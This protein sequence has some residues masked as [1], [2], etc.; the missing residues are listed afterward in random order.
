VI[1]SMSGSENFRSTIEYRLLYAKYFQNH[2]S[3]RMVQSDFYVLASGRISPYDDLIR[4]YS[5]EIGW[6][7]RLLASM[8]YQESRFLPD[9]QS[10]A[11]ADGLMQLMPNTA[12]RFGVNEHL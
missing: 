12:R 2:R 8:I 3:A 1:Q 9:A 11:G 5:E 7:W 6:D 4:K 10:W